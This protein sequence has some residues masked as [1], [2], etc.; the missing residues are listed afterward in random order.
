[1]VVINALRQATAGFHREVEVSAVMTPLADGRVTIPQYLFA[2]QALAG[3]Y[4]PAEDLLFVRFAP[5]ASALGIRPKLPAL[6]DDLHVLGLSRDQI[7]QLPACTDLP[8]IDDAAA[9]IGMFYV[10]EGATL[11]GQVVMRRIRE[12]LGPLYGR[13]TSFH[14]FHGAQAGSHWRG[15]QVNLEETI[16]SRPGGEAAARRGAI[17]TFQALLR[18][19]QSC[20]PG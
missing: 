5:V 8:R 9:A 11:G 14:G 20:P 16:Q 18:W 4:R 17:D 15:F 7:G 12:G 19:L 1:M 10:L 13:A 3:F 2:L 6:L